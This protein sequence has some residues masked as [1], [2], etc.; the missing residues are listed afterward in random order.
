MSATHPRPVAC[1]AAAP[2][3]RA[4]NAVAAGARIDVVTAD[5]V[6]L[7]RDVNTT[8]GY[9]R[10]THDGDIEYLFVNP[11]HRRRGFGRR[12]LQEVER[13]TGRRGVPLPPISPLGRRFFGL[14]VSA[15]IPSNPPPA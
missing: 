13:L 11:A 9:C 12:L 5:G 7:I 4:A 10:H 3:R 6:V 14:D 1:D 8:I 15:A 2:D